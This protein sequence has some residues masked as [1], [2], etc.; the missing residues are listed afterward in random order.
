MNTYKRHRFP[1]DIISYAAWLCYRFHLSHRDIEDLLAER[2]VTV[3]RESI[4]LWCIKFD[5]LYARRLKRKHRGYG[6]TFYIDEVCVKINGKQHY[7]W[8]AVDQDG[9][10]V[11]V[12]LQA[13][14]DGVAAKR[15]FRRLLRSNGGEPSKIVTDK[16]RSYGVAHRELIPETIHSTKQYENNRAEQSHEST[17]VRECGMRRFKSVR[18]AQRFPGT[19]AAVSIFFNL[20]RHMVGAEH[21]RNLRTSAFTE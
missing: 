10:V 17:R 6:D 12:Y 1:P 19:H 4:R 2:C 9:E 20:G 5:A 13:R 8:R 14:R 18:Q 11:D 21:Y 15:F 16:L 3:T 7:A